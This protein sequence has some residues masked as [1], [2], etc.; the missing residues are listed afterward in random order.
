MATRGTDL[1]PSL[2][3]MQHA[4]LKQD[5]R[6]GSAGLYGISLACSLSCSLVC[7]LVWLIALQPNAKAEPA[8]PNAPTTPAAIMPA[9]S[10]PLKDQQAVLKAFD[11]EPPSPTNTMKVFAMV[12]GW[13]HELDVPTKP[14]V[15]AYGN[16][17][18]VTLRLDH[19]II[20]RGTS[21]LGNGQAAWDATRIAIAEAL[22]RLPGSNDAV[23]QAAKRALGPKMTIS[24]ELG[25]QFIPI[26]TSSWQAIDTRVRPA[27]DGVAARIT[28]DNQTTIAL[29][30]PSV[31]RARGDLPSV[32]AVRAV[33]EA[34]GDPNLAIKSDPKSSPRRLADEHGVAILGFKVTHLAQFAP[35]QSATF[36][37]RGQRVVQSSEIDKASIQEWSIKLAQHLSRRSGTSTYNPAAGTATGTALAPE[38]AITV[39]ALEAR[40]AMPGVP[41]PI[42][43]EARGAIASIRNK[44]ISQAPTKVAFS[45]MSA[46]ALVLAGIDK[47]DSPEAKALVPR[48]HESLASA[49]SMNGGWNKAV[50]EAA[51]G[52]VAWG[53]VE[54]A[55]NDATLAEAQRA[56]VLARAQ[57]AIRAVYRETAEGNLVMHL[58]W[59]YY[60]EVGLAD[61]SAPAPQLPAAA[62]LRNARDTITK[63]QL[64]RADAGDDGIDLVGGIVYTRGGATLPTAASA[65]AISYL[66]I[67]LGDARLTSI[68][69]S[70][71]EL[72]RMLAGFRFLKQL[73]L[74][75]AS[76]YFA[77]NPKVALGG[78]QTSTWDPAQPIEASAIALLAACDGLKALDT[79]SARLQSSTSPEP[80]ATP[81][82]TPTQTPATNAP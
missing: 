67:T 19:A 65:R 80:T 49:F 35:G 57:A 23:G 13:V 42:A 22:A 50:P 11:V 40:L 3:M 73:T 4:S 6:D 28:K 39:R 27:M 12:E 8:S 61:R 43:D 53:L 7:S 55:R 33:A 82:Q 45:S 59:L 32:G 47:V 9:P 10:T 70:L 44:L 48:V 21:S 18:M 63:H 77:V 46:A 71:P 78:I 74:D 24:L 72:T 37:Y 69:E 75:E 25:G 56:E 2:V 51:R 60:A 31:M 66:A 20:G 58:P 30:F 38:L 1:V 5:A 62:A 26:G 64:T 14:V 36:L 15:L 29:T 17:A 81:A 16:A 52:F 79:L 76:G 54:L 68:E 41:E 34:S